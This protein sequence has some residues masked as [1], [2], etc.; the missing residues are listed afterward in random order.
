MLRAATSPIDV[1]ENNS[2]AGS[3]KYYGPDHTHNRA[4]KSQYCWLRQIL[5]IL[6]SPIT[7]KATTVLL[8][9]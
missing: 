6:T 5:R 7:V 4:D 3:M 9:P 8:A 1:Q 2:I